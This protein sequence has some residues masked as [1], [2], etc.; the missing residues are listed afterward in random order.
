MID[1]LFLDDFSGLPE[2]RCSMTR[3]VGT[4]LATCLLCGLAGYSLTL[5]L[6]RR[7]WP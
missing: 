1:D 5:K 4:Y 7:F 6:A 2:L 3:T